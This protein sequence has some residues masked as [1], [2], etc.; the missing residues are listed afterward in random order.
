MR[1]AVLRAASWL[2]P[3][4][5]ATLAPRPPESLAALAR[6][7][8]AA[9]RVHRFSPLAHQVL[10]SVLDEL[11]AL[12]ARDL[13]CV[14]E[15]GDFSLR[16]TLVDGPA[17]AVVDWAE[18]DLHGA[19]FMDLFHLFTMAAVFR[20]N[21]SMRL[22]RLVDAYTESHY[23]AT[24][25]SD[26]ARGV[27]AHYAQALGL[28]RDAAHPLFPVLLARLATREHDALGV[29]GGFDRFWR[30]AIEIFAE[31]RSQFLWL[32]EIPTARGERDEGALE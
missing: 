31:R 5:E 6:P 29:S 19:P 23:E 12:T 3:F 27:F 20:R 24:W 13:P 7:I 18:G 17:L 11:T 8:Y 10:D 26:V 22:T 21:Q 28:T 32:G 1:A 4:H 15:H 25:V 2:L 9:R 16:N 30:D 14:C